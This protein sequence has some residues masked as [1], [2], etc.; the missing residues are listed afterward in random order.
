[1][2]ERGG[3]GV[4]R[5]SAFVAIT[6]AAILIVG[7]AS[8][9]VP[10]ESPEL[11]NSDVT[12]TPERASSLAELDP[13][14][15]ID[16]QV[17]HEYGYESR[18]SSTMGPSHTCLYSTTGTDAL[19]IAFTDGG[20]GDLRPD[21]SNLTS[22]QQFGSH[23]AIRMESTTAAMCTIVIDIG[24]RESVTVQAIQPTVEMACAQAADIAFRVEPHLPP[25]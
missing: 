18:T 20:I 2:H 1:M 6:V 3:H 16:D 11:T 15:L 8:N 4:A 23:R 25:A 9:E 14:A 22:S 7:C 24:G 12:D 5:L 21:P 10:P 13:C 17:V 19:T